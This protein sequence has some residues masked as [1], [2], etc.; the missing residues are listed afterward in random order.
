[1]GDGMTT[2]PQEAARGYDGAERDYDRD[3][4]RA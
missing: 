3:Y 4:D 1:M 2:P